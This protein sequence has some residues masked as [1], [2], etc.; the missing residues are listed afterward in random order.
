MAQAQTVD[1]YE[2]EELARFLCGAAETDQ[3]I[4]L[5]D[6][7]DD[8]FGADFDAFAKIV[9]ALCPMIAVS[10]SELSGNHYRGFA[11]IDARTFLVKQKIEEST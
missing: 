3:D 10:R 4:D 7:L 8:R 9:S 6:A 2:I 11:D 5:D 1:G